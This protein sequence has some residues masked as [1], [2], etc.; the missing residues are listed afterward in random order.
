MKQPKWKSRWLKQRKI[1]NRDPSLR[2]FKY[3][4]VGNHIR[5]EKNKIP[6]PLPECPACAQLGKVSRFRYVGIYTMTRT[7]AKKLKFP[8]N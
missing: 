8:R 1:D 3:V 2:N 4:C 5:I 6:D 7:D